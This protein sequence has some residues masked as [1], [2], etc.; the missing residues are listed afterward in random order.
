[1]YRL[2]VLVISAIMGL[3]LAQPVQAQSAERSYDQGARAYRAQDM[4]TARD[5]FRRACDFGHGRA[6]YNYGI[7]SYQGL[8]DGEPDL[9]HARWLYNRACEFDYAA[10]CFNL[11]RMAFNGEG[12]TVDL[13]VARTGFDT[14]CNARL[15]NGCNG[16]AIML[17]QGQGGHLRARRLALVRIAA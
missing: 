15:A 14:S 1:M 11:A 4:T 13:A 9:E 6:C 10:G 17:E 3:G 8:V 12:G 2:T 16:F 7:M 5:H